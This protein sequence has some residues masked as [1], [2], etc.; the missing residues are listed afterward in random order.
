M[1]RLEQLGELGILAVGGQQVLLHRVQVEH[2]EVGLGRQVAD[3]EQRR[4]RLE[5]DPDGHGLLEALARAAQLEA[6]LEQ[7]SRTRRRSEQSSTKGT[8]MRTSAP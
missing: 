6:L 5:H 2:Q 7:T 8:A 1:E 4:G 3:A